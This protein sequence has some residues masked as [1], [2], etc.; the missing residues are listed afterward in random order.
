MTQ[1]VIQNFEIFYKSENFCAT[2]SKLSEEF[3]KVSEFNFTLLSEANTFSTGESNLTIFVISMKSVASAIPERLKICQKYLFCI[4]DNWK[5]RISEYNLFSQWNFLMTLLLLSN[6]KSNKS[7]CFDLHAPF[8]ID[9]SIEPALQN[10]NHTETTLVSALKRIWILKKSDST[11]NI[12]KILNQK[13]LFDL[14]PSKIA[15]NKNIVMGSYKSWPWKWRQRI[16][17]KLENQNL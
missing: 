8:L 17:W 4:I 3:W 9:N 12:E 16:C 5:Y 2:Y 7:L 13:F 10:F 11:F 6:L 14:R 15:C 1:C